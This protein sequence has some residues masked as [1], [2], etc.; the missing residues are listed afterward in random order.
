[1]DI[2]G[3]VTQHPPKWLKWMP[4]VAVSIGA[5]SAL[6]ATFILYPWH[7]EISKELLEMKQK[8]QLNT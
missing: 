2:E 7:L 1:M 3:Q 4:L 8:C 5:Y 6:F